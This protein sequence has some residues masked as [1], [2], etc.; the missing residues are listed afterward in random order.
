MLKLQRKASSLGLSSRSSPPRPPN[1]L[2]RLQQGA[3]PLPLPPRRSLLRLQRANPLPQVSSWAAE[4]A[5]PLPLSLPRLRREPISSPK[6]P[7]EMRKE[8]IP[9]HRL[10]PSCRREPI[11]ASGQLEKLPQGTSPSLGRL[12]LLEEMRPGAGSPTQPS[13][14]GWRSESPG[15]RGATL[16]PPVA[17]CSSSPLRTGQTL[18]PQILWESKLFAGSGRSYPIPQEGSGQFS[19]PGITSQA[20]QEPRAPRPTISRKFCHPKI[21]QTTEKGK[22]ILPTCSN[23]T[24][25]ARPSPKQEEGRHNPEAAHLGRQVLRFLL[26][27]NVPHSLFTLALFKSILCLIPGPHLIQAGKKPLTDPVSQF[28]LPGL[29]S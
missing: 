6:S 13:Q 10:L 8:P 1:L 20:G 9:S 25:P 14:L 22:A 3:N 15:G 17:S 12:R 2:P 5:N 11:S 29:V 21:G 26:A 23:V 24:V 18:L 7:L 16:L 4:R 28:R 19:R 27:T